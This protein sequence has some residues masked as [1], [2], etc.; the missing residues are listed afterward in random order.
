MRL[1]DFDLDLQVKGNEDGGMEPNGI[2]SQ[3]VSITVTSYLQGCT[4][5]CTQKC[6]VK[7]TTG[8]YTP[9]TYTCGGAC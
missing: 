2:S 6:T 1:N 5:G 7:C 9:H 8:Q 3:V 4:P